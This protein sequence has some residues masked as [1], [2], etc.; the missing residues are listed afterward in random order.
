MERLCSCCGKLVNG[1]KGKLMDK[2]TSI[3]NFICNSCLGIGEYVP[4]EEIEVFRKILDK[5]KKQI[6]INILDYADKH[7]KF[8]NRQAQT[9][10]NCM[11]YKQLKKYNLLMEDIPELIIA[12]LTEKELKEVLNLIEA[13]DYKLRKKDKVFLS[14]NTSNEELLKKIESL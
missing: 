5:S 4:T 2:H 6:V 14:S 8:S 10:I 7:N 1:Y 9:L 13:K 11:T 12:D 3:E